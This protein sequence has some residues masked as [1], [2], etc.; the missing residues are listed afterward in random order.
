MIGRIFNHS[1]PMLVVITLILSGG[2]RTT[3][4]MGD[5]SKLPYSPTR[6]VVHIRS[7]VN[8][9]VA[10]GYKTLSNYRVVSES[11]SQTEIFGNEGETHW[12]RFNLN[13]DT[14][15]YKAWLVGHP[16][17]LGRFDL[18]L[19]KASGSS[20]AVK[21]SLMYTALD[22]EGAKLLEEIPDAKIQLLLH[23]LHNTQPADWK[24]HAPLVY[25][26]S[27]KGFVVGSVEESFHM[28][29]AMEELRWVPGW[30]P[31]VKFSDKRNGRS[32]LNTVFQENKGALSFGLRSDGTS[33]WQ[34]VEYD[35]AARRFT[36][37]FT[38]DHD[39]VGALAFRFT[40]QEED[41]TLWEASASLT[42]LTSRGKAIMEQ[43][44]LAYSDPKET[45]QRAPKS[46]IQ[47][48]AHA[49]KTGKVFEV[50]VSKRMGLVMSAMWGSLTE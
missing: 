38:I 1:A 29:G 12:Y 8:D 15:G 37:L 24:P 16:H 18:E 20:V 41:N 17:L 13:G 42:S 23:R 10:G 19:Q 30:Q 22:V 32:G 47:W 3:A 45:V 21:S 43:E 28:P 40:Q 6:K 46:L 49:Q 35:K 33:H 2:C 5:L 50:P 31:E 34:I 36:V 9:S 25:Q 11:F 48:A 44:G 4:N 7:N 26:S 14:S 39:V 27:A